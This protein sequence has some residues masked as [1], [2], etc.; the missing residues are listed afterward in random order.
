MRMEEVAKIRMKCAD[1]LI[2]RLI[3]TLKINRWLEA[4][5]ESTE[6][7]TEGLHSNHIRVTVSFTNYHEIK[8]FKLYEVTVEKSGM[9]HWIYRVATKY[10]HVVQF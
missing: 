4:Y 5:H 1:K 8:M 9:E 6:I 2:N 3:I 10:A 7:F